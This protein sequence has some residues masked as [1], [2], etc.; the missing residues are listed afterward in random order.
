MAELW[1]EGQFIADACVNRAHAF[2][3]GGYSD[4]RCI[5]ILN[6]NDTR[7]RA[8]VK[9]TYSL[10][11]QTYTAILAPIEQSGACVFDWGAV[12]QQPISLTPRPNRTSTRRFVRSGEDGSVLMCH[13]TIGADN[14]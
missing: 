6:E 12:L 11:P 3:C 1:C 10:F 5:H 4:Q 8:R 14:E 9:E 2:V 13:H 7:L